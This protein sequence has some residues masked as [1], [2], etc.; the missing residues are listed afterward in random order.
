MKLSF[1]QVSS[2]WLAELED[3]SRAHTGSIAGV[4]NTLA[5]L[6]STAAPL[7]AGTVIQA[8]FSEAS[9]V[10]ILDHSVDVSKLQASG[11]S[12]M[13]LICLAVNLSWPELLS[14]VT[15]A[16]LRLLGVA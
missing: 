4:G 5:T 10:G 15:G 2:D 9:A 6:S 8:R 11:W 13:F 7:I 14:Y 3:I 16:C 12:S 1:F